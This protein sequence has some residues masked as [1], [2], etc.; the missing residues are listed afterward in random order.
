MNINLVARFNIE[1]NIL[2]FEEKMPEN[3]TIR[4]LELFSNYFFKELLELWDW[5]TDQRLQVLRLDTLPEFQFLPK[6]LTD[7]K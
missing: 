3:F 4:E 7:Y 5:D 6:V 2:Y 1:Y